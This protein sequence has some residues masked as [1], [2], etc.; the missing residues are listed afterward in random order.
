VIAVDSN[1]LVYARRQEF[2][3]HQPALDALRELAEGDEPWAL[4]LFCIGE[5]LRVV[6]HPRLFDP[7]T[8]PQAALR[9]VD[10]LL[11]SPTVR[12]L[13][14]GRD[15]HRIFGRLIAQARVSGNGVFDTQIAALCLESGVSEI[16]SE[17]RDFLR[18]QAIRLRTL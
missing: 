5:F 15:F 4:P 18:F 6:T 9:F 14:P 8:D 16:L 2:P 7:P 17:D 1:I 11:E 12:L 10:A 3:Q 13:L